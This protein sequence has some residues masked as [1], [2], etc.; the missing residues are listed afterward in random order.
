MGDTLAAISDKWSG[1]VSEEF[2]TNLPPFIASRP[3][4]VQLVESNHVKT[5]DMPRIIHT[6]NTGKSFRALEIPTRKI[7]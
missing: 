5:D 1:S 4:L 2:R 7:D 3:D 6:L